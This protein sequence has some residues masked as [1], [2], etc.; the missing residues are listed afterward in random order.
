MA[1]EYHVAV[2]GATGA[3][4]N[5]MI[6]ILEE[7]EFPLASLKLLASSRSAGK[8]LEFRGED[9]PV[10]ELREDSFAGLDIALFSAGGGPSR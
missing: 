1:K 8:T 5:E 3:V 7:L 9:L 6:N 10:E 2:A 4:G